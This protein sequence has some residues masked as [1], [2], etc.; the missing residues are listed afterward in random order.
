MV[1]VEYRKIKE[2]SV[3]LKVPVSDIPEHARKYGFFNPEMKTDR[4][5]SVCALSCF[6]KIFM[7]K[8]GN[9]GKELEICD[10]LCA[11]GAR[12]LRYKT[13]AG[14]IVTM[15]D[16][17]ENA[18]E[19]A[20]INCESNG[21]DIEIT[22]KDANLLL[23]E[24]NFDVIDIDPF[25]SPYPFIDS[26]ARSLGDT[27]MLMV[28]ATDTAALFGVY[29]EVSE[30][31]YG[32]PSIKCDFSKEMG[33]R[34]LASFVIRE[35]AKYNMCFTPVLCYSR[36]HYVRI[37]GIVTKSAEKV[38]SVM[39]KFNCLSANSVEWETGV[40]KRS[41]TKM[42]GK[43][44]LGPLC[45]HGFCSS[46]LE[47]IGKRKLGGEKLVTTI[48]NESDCLFY[49]ETGTLSSSMGLNRKISEILQGLRENGFLASRTVF[50]DTGIK[51]SA[52]M[53]DMMEVFPA[54]HGNKSA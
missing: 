13:E 46:V 5:I 23:A 53:K 40:Q 16:I 27:G 6:G 45:E 32:I 52:A 11:T 14:G 4:D 44:Y 7:E 50:S 15:N 19:L 25:G 35:L 31:R 18:V 21:I 30:R 38:E 8:S 41:D 42:L 10:L 33:T 47:E 2:G 49:Y 39:K 37:M 54:V 26:A 48:L 51:T 3:L 17:N 36:R 1:T 28:T 20:K 22:N 34:I 12:G 24:R 29:P 9:P 43:V